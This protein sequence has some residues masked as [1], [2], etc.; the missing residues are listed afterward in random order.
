MIT[1]VRQFIAD[2]LDDVSATAN[3]QEGVA[4]SVV[5]DSLEV[6]RLRLDGEEWVFAYTDDFRRQENIKP[7]VDFPN[8]D[9]EYRSPDLWP[10]FQL[11]IPSLKQP[12]VQEFLREEKVDIP[13][14]A[15]LLRRFG[16]RS[17]ANPF[18]LVPSE[19]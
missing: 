8:T 9:R 4:F 7:I 10:F 18:E 13:S 19:A 3:G 6:G 5:L 17:A 12:V 11:R 15:I 1:R 16:K 14:A 2:W